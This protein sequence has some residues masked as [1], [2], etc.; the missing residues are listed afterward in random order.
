MLMLS[1]FISET[2]CESGGDANEASFSAPAGVL[3]A[4]SEP[5]K[6]MPALCSAARSAPAVKTA[7]S[8]TTSE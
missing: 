5:S 4:L 2:I 8:S 3:P 7:G 6:V 1:R